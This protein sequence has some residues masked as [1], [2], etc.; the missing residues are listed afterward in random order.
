MHNQVSKF[1]D[2]P[3]VCVINKV[4]TSILACSLQRNPCLLVSCSATLVC[5]PPQERLLGRCLI[6]FC[7]ALCSLLSRKTVLY[8]PF[9]TGQRSLYC[10]LTRWS[11]KGCVFPPF[12]LTCKRFSVLCSCSAMFPG[13]MSL[14]A[15]MVNAV[16]AATAKQ[17][18]SILCYMEEMDK[19]KNI[20]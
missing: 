20:E 18:E 3:T 7:G 15:N 14:T 10:A 1:A 19:Q 4:L 13:S 5:S 6:F 12:P 11:I 2:Q 16:A 9:W 17:A 8:Q